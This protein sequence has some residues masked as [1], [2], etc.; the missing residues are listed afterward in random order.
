MI[1]E[2]VDTNNQIHHD[3]L[4]IESYVQ[5]LMQN[6]ELGFTTLLDNVRQQTNAEDFISKSVSNRQNA[7]FLMLLNPTVTVHY[8]SPQKS[9]EQAIIHEVKRYPIGPPDFRY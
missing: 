4:Q 5:S 2:N 9:R 7:P 1:I 3:N 6:I 8:N